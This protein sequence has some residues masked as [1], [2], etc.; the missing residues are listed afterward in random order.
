MT[1]DIAESL[2]LG[3][4]HGALIASVTPGGPADKAGIQAGDVITEFDGKPIDEMRKLPREVADTPVDK[5][6]PVKLIRQGKELTKTVKVAEMQQSDD[7]EQTT[8]EGDQTA[9]QPAGVKV[10]SLGLEVGSITDELRKQ[11]SVGD[12]VKGLLVTTVDPNGPAGDRGIAAGDVI[13]SINQE[14]VT[15]PADLTAKVEAAR[16]A[17]KKSVLL[18]IER[19]GEIRFVAVNLAKKDQ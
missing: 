6:V 7:E 3:K 1:D 19:H 11:Y 18:L 5:S 17:G 15:K 2:G 8:E 4:T 9:P 13:T 10:A 16:K 12:T 14:E